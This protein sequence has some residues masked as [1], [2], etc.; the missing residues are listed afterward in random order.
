[1]WDPNYKGVYHLVEDPSTAGT[2]G[3]KDSTSNDH[4]GTDQGSMVSGDQIAG[5]IGGSLNFDAAAKYIDFGDVDD[6]DFGT[7]DFSVSL[8][9][10][11]GGGGSSNAFVTKNT[12]NNPYN[13][14]YIYYSGSQETYT[15]YGPGYV[16]FNEDG[17]DG[18]WHYLVA[19][20]EG[21]GTNEFKVY[22]NGVV[23][24]TATLSTNL[25]NS[26]S[27]LMHRFGDQ[28]AAATV[29]QFDETRLSNKA[30]SASWIATEYN[31][32]SSPS[33]FYSYDP[34]SY[35][36]DEYGR[37]TA[38]S[39]SYFRA[40]GTQDGTIK[41]S[42]ETAQEI[43]NLG[44]Y[45]YQAQNP[46]G[47]FARIT[48]KM[49]PGLS[50]S[51]RGKK[52][53]YCDVGVTPGT[54]YYYKLED[55]EIS[56]KRTMHG[57]ICVDWDGDGMPDD[58][59]IA[60]G[61][62][63]GINDSMLDPDGDGLTN[64][65]EY[66]RGTDPLNSD[67]DGD[68]ICDGDEDKRIDQQE[69]PLATKS[70]KQPVK[71]ISSDDTGITLE[72]HTDAFE[73]EKIIAED[74]NTY[75]RLRIRD[76]IHGFT[77]EVGWPELPFKGV[78]LDLPEEKEARIQV[79]GTESTIHAGYSVYPL[80][81]KVVNKNKGIDIVT[82]IFTIDQ[83]AYADDALY[84]QDI[85]RCG[86]IYIFRDQRKLHLLLY[87]LIFNPVA[88][89]L[90]HF[91][92]IRVRID[93]TKDREKKAILSRKRVAR[94]RAW[95][96]PPSEALYK[97][98][99]SDEGIYRLDKGYLASCGLS[100]D[101]ID[102]SR[103]RLY[104]LG[105]EVALSIHDQ[106]G[107]N[108]L[109]FGDYS[110]FYGEPVDERYAKYTN[111][112]VY[113]LITDG[114]EGAPK[115]MA[116]LDCAPAGGA[117]PE[118]FIDTIHY[119]QDEYYLIM[120]P[121]KD[122]LD[123]WVFE[124]AIQGGGI[125]WVDQNIPAPGSI[126]PFTLTLPGVASA[127]IL[128]IKMWGLSVSEHEVEIYHND[129]HYE[130]VSWYGIAPYLATLDGVALVTGS[131][132]VGLK[133]NGQTDIVVVDWIEATYPRSFAA[134]NDELVFTLNAGERQQITGFNQSDLL[135]FDIT[136]PD[137]ARAA[138]NFSVTGGAEPY[139]LDCEPQYEGG[140]YGERTL[141]A[142]SQGAQRFPSSFTAQ[143]HDDLSSPENGA[144]YIVITHRNIGWDA[145]GA[146]YPW[147]SDLVSLRE[148]QGLRVQ[149]IDVEKIYNEFAYGIATPQAI[150]DFLEYA[151]YHW[152]RPAPQYVVLLGD[153]TYDYKN[154]WDVPE[155]N[156]AYLP[157][158]LSCASFMGEVPV[159]DW[160]VMLEGGDELPDIHIG[161]LP[162]AN[163]EQA[164]VMV[165]KILAYE[166]ALNSKTW[167]KNVLFVADKQTAEYE[168]LFKI[169]SDDSSA[170]VPLGLNEPFKGYLGDYR[171]SAGLNEDIK[172][173]INEGS[174]MVNYSG[175]GST[176][177]WGMDS[178]FGNTDVT[179]LTN[180]R[181]LPFFVSMTCLTGYFTYP[182]AWGFPC[183]AE[184]LLRAEDGGAISAFMSVGMTDPVWQ[185]ILNTALFDALFTEDVRILGPAISLAKQTLCANE[186]GPEPEG[187]AFLLFGDPAMSLKVHIP[188]KP[189]N[190]KAED[191]PG[192][193]GGIVLSWDDAADCEGDPVFAYNL[194]RSTTPDG[195][196][197]MAC[198]L[199]PYSVNTYEE[200]WGRSDTTYYYVLTS[201]DFDGDESVRSRSVRGRTGTIPGSEP[202]PPRPMDTSTPAGTVIVVKAPPKPPQDTSNLGKGCFIDSL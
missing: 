103:I 54:L 107:D 140:K 2:G 119:E 74:K 189:V 49:I 153:S 94:A 64:I 66:E 122:E 161:R 33:T 145:G 16:Y 185:H 160:F 165:K 65:E 182:E 12:Y 15:W 184:A 82:E 68:G 114:G 5:R 10:K 23:A 81:E 195:E 162:A 130:T 56:G 116:Q 118:T 13:G 70:V 168:A 120:L 127:G 199:I 149:V 113:F 131:N 125:E 136:A 18:Q 183:M 169:M 151:Y 28:Q 157:A 108:L 92:R 177:V 178:I 17:L 180:D 30:R 31:N 19:V 124:D 171:S 139:T 71:I 14:V 132:T 146:L 42:W 84:P 88:K 156:A 152:S 4:D 106:D 39:L 79:I 128:E 63:P 47:P 187:Q 87:P 52:Y 77:N 121:G 26:L 7:S 101:D 22:K 45:L 167:E 46:F 100:V 163:A 40:Q 62:D 196:Y 159:D 158:Y 150:K 6:F 143:T 93:F 102:L 112:N 73:R 147:L 97:I 29:T 38:V 83:A 24:N 172:T 115:R 36:S 170:L 138:V 53:A 197:S 175:H 110:I 198:G 201:V 75:D 173:K 25:T 32:Q 67:T 191:E 21:T 50:F 8:W 179:V 188:R 3:I 154:N 35:E 89:E 123:R 80:P 144:D 109:D 61:L 202:K 34:N 142:L 126:V 134:E 85:A 43:D 69:K 41:L 78:L 166:D 37:P 11:G 148:G 174:L 193:K 86:D 111:D 155:H 137:E 200:A 44:F 117:I 135:L 48:D 192:A 176:Q 141:Y 104:N 91:S 96:P 72:L 95:S 60:D 20:R 55:V 181:M 164:E 9:V 99:L 186:Y 1:M 58:W 76:Y 98:I 133:C 51:V 27:F 90:T 194:Y 105:R 59:E 129:T 190:L 57:P